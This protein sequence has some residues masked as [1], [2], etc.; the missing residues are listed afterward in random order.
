MTLSLQ[1]ESLERQGKQLSSRLASTITSAT[2]HPFERCS[3]LAASRR[4]TGKTLATTTPTWWAKTSRASLWNPSA[5]AWSASSRQIKTE[6]YSPTT[7]SKKCAPKSTKRLRRWIWTSTFQVLSKTWSHRKEILSHRKK[8]AVLSL[9]QSRWPSWT[10]W[11]WIKC[12]KIS[13]QRARS[14]L[15]SCPS[16][17]CYRASSLRLPMSK[18]IRRSS[19]RRSF[20]KSWQ[21]TFNCNIRHQ[22]IIIK[23]KA[24]FTLTT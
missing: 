20:S 11:A 12:S 16:E 14:T 3:R 13:N 17:S 23:R 10:E 24:S 5:P 8:T 19:T 15:I 6:S 7:A 2:C 21:V 1:N 18:E 9:P 4:L 22:R